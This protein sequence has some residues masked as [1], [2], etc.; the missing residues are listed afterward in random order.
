MK[1]ENHCQ[2][3][4]LLVFFAEGSSNAALREVLIGNTRTNSLDETKLRTEQLQRLTVNLLA[5]LLESSEY[6]PA[7]NSRLNVVTNSYWA[8]QKDFSI[9]V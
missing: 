7:S 1:F 5:T 8:I 9:N 2:S 4:Q 6:T 3:P